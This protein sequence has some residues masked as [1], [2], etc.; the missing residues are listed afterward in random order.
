M[1]PQLSWTISVLVQTL[2]NLLLVQRQIHQRML[3]AHLH[4]PRHAA[5]PVII[6]RQHK[7]QRHQVFIGL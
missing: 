6:R 7:I 5:T 4:N 3:L 2:L 1:V